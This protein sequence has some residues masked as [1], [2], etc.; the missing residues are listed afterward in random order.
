MDGKIKVPEGMLTAGNDAVMSQS[1]CPCSTCVGNREAILEAA[2]LWLSENPIVPTVAQWSDIYHNSDA[3]SARWRC[4][5]WQRRMF[6]SPEPEVGQ[7]A[8]RI[9]DGMRGCTLTPADAD[10]IVEEVSRVSHGWSDPRRKG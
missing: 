5:E 6:L 4:V 9:I 3:R 10:A 2:L 7:A 8:R 1:C